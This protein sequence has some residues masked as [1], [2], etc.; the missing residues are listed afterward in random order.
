MEGITIRGRVEKGM[1]LSKL[2][3]WRVG[4]PAAFAVWPADE[5]ELLSV[6]RY[7]RER[8]L[9]AVVLG[10]GS[11]VLAPDE[12]WEGIAVITTMLRRAEWGAD[13]VRAGAGCSLA[14]LAREAARRSL[15]GLEFAGGIPG[16]LGGAAV[17]N[18]GAYGRDMSEVIAQAR[19]WTPEG[20]SREVSG[21]EL[22]FSYRRSTLQCG[23]RLLTEAT[24]SLTPGEPAAI[25]RVMADHREWRR[26]TQPL[27]LPSAGSVFRN[28]AGDHAGRL[29]DEAG[30]KGRRIGGAEVSV[31][32]AN[33]IVNRGGATAGDI[34]ALITAVREDVERRF[35]VRLETEIKFL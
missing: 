21:A 17:M 16:T 22:G 4:G 26:K 28:P 12:G 33:F 20:G 15:S 7:G 23:G 11:N 9:P 19:I 35:R 25:R 1:S 8:G 27:G 6:L 18:A 14:A 10:R 5:E 31:R 32:N 13:A 3:T 34:R 29:I 24:L 30:W 2:T